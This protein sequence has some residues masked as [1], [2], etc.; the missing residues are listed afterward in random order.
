MT[1]IVHGTILSMDDDIKQHIFLRYRNGSPLPVNTD[2]KDKV[3]ELVE[4]L[5]QNSDYNQVFRGKIKNIADGYGAGI[6]P[7]STWHQATRELFRRFERHYNA[8]IPNPTRVAL[9]GLVELLTSSNDERLN[10]DEL[11]EYLVANLESLSPLRDRSFIIDGNEIYRGADGQYYYENSDGQ[12]VLVHGLKTPAEETLQFYTDDI[13]MRYGRLYYILRFIALFDIAYE[14]EHNQQ[15]FHEMLACALFDNNGDTRYLDWQ[16]QM[17]IQFDFVPMQ[18]HPRSPYSN[19]DWLGS[20]LVM[21]LPYPNTQ[22]H[23]SVLPFPPTNKMID[24]FNGAFRGHKYQLEIPLDGS[25]LFGTEPECY[26]DFLGSKV[27]VVNGNAFV[28]P[29][30]ITPCDEDDGS[31]GLAVAR[32]FMSAVNASHE[33]RLVEQLKSVQKPRLQPWFR[34]TRIGVFHI[35]EPE[36]TLPHD[37][38]N[39]GEDKWLSLAFMREAVSSNSIYYSFLNYYK[40]VELLN[41]NDGK[42]VEKWINEN[43]EQICK[44]ANIDWYEKLVLVGKINNPSYYLYKTGRVAVAHV[45]YTIDKK[46]RPNSPDSP[47]DWARIETDLVVM[48]ALA[49]EAMKIIK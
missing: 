4:P 2:V 16:W 37:V 40:V 1:L 31:D 44:A 24:A 21:H 39:Y 28:Q 32:K 8:P 9:I 42:K 27:R 5:K 18:W 12:R 17:P 38:E 20:D 49:K 26:F 41:D 46:S 33:I 10:W 45:E 13:Q 25:I 7:D 43:V 35:I 3:R 47:S 29:V 6:H 34:Q 14:Y 11:R 48:R 36:Y 15:D 23:E 19:P 30:L 22:P